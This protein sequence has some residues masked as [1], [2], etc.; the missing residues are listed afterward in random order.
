MLFRSVSQSRYKERTYIESL[1]WFISHEESYSEGKAGNV[2][3][4]SLHRKRKSGVPLKGA[5]VSITYTEYSYDSVY[6]GGDDQPAIIAN[7]KKRM[8]PWS[9]GAKNKDTITCAKFDHATDSFIRF[10]KELAPISQPNKE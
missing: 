3:L 2:S 4:L 10:A 1:G 5:D 8:K 6:D 9:V 7:R